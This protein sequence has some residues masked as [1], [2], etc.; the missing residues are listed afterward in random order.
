MR[1]LKL[2]LAF[3]GTNY[4]G[5]QRQKGQVAIQ[6]VLEEKLAV[7]T[8]EAVTVEGAGRTDAGVHALGMVASLRT[9]STIPAIGLLKGLNSMLPRDIRVL[10]LTEAADDFHARYS[11]V[12]K[13]YEYRLIYAEVGLPTERLYNLR[14]ARP[15]D[16]QVVDRCLEMLVGRH[17]FSSFEAAGSR[18]PQA[19]QGR[20]AVRRIFRA[21]YRLAEG[22]ELTRA[23]FV[24]IGDGFLRHMV[25]NLV[26]TLIMVGRGKRTVGEFAAIMAARDRS[27]A[28]PTAP[29]HG[30]FL[31]QVYYDPAQVDQAGQG[32]FS[33]NGC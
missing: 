20:G 18:D 7:I 31:R 15:L 27:Q 24:F 3:D 12:A 21:D 14:L 6:Q 30:L 29:A 13:A 19:D 10:E 25:R 1:T 23:K 22:E 5:W 9:T 17:D 33:A 16:R 2:T 26:G 11:A 8:Q 32:S 4:A 28:G